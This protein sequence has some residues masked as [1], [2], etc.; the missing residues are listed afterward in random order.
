MPIAYS[1]DLRKRVISLCKQYS[2]EEVAEMLDIHAAT[3][4]RYLKRFIEDDTLQPKP[5]NT[6]NHPS[7]IVDLV[8]F[9]ARNE[10]SKQISQDTRFRFDEFVRRNK[11]LTLHEIGK[12]YG[13]SHNAVFKSLRKL[14][15]SF[16]KNNR[17]LP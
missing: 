4:Y 10:G 16:K 17:P 6:Y 9:D 12:R 2:K 7:K 11:N 3:V 14:G 8:E 1:L 5:L 13:C 15:Y